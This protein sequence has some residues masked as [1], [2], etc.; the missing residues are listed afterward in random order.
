[1]IG[2]R[3][4]GIRH[5]DL[6]AP[7]PELA[8]DAPLFVVFWLGTLPLGSTT[9][10][11]EELPLAPPQVA[12]LAARIIA[13]AVGYWLVGDAFA[14]EVPNAP[15]LSAE[16][17]R[18]A[19]FEGLVGLERPLER[20]AAWWARETAGDGAQARSG[21]RPSLSVIVCT[22]DR[23]DALGEC[24]DAI[25]ASSDA[26]DE[27]IVVDNAPSD[28]ATRRVVEARGGVRYVREDRPGLS[29]A[30]NAG[31]RASTSALV[32]FTDDD[33]EVHPQW[34][35][36]VRSALGEGSHGAMTG[37]VL[38]ASLETPS[39]YL[40]EMKFG[41]FSQGFRPIV[42][43]REFRERTLA[44]SPPVWRIGAGANMAFRRRA[45]E[46]VGGFDE[47][48]GAGRAGCSEDSE[49]WYR[50]LAA[51]ISCVY[52]P[53]AVVFHHH[54]AELGALRKQMRAYASGHAAALLVQFERTR[55]WGNLKRLLLS[56][57]RY[58]AAR[59]VRRLVHVRPRTPSTY[60]EEVVGALSGVG[61]YLKRRRD[62]GAPPLPA[63]DGE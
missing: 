61:Y 6:A 26:P 39:Q 49:L 8:G 19:S 37:L 3:P 58:Y 12:E 45:L 30:R 20:L 11:A 62:P 40:F 7:L 13:P 9:L 63:R 34:T 27:V 33:V 25:A 44:W 50:M 47:R 2:F 43:D 29:A 56:L 23:P 10:D 38:P 35:A 51:G 15:D 22:R 28:D 4:W 31:L 32:A 36:W 41:G 54:R 24:L 59:V 42:F 14:P 21:P 1:M 48:L 60:L 17:L 52:D 53:R 57:P 18:T 55:E 5:V 46:A 16:R